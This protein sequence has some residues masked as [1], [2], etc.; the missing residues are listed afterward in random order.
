MKGVD[1]RDHADCAIAHPSF[2]TDQLLITVV[3]AVSADT[4]WLTYVIAAWTSAHARKV[5]AAEELALVLVRVLPFLKLFVENTG[6]VVRPAFSLS[7]F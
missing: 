1:R 6:M 7:L 3:S 5:V 4:M 2:Y